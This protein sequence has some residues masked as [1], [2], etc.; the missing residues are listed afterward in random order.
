L[1]IFDLSLKRK[2]NNAGAGRRWRAVGRGKD[3]AFLGFLIRGSVIE[4]VVEIIELVLGEGSQRAIGVY[5]SH[6]AS[7]GWG[8][9]EKGG[10]SAKK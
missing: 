10:K 2:T 1:S 4:P 5:F 6:K 3:D 7:R 9:V 8:V